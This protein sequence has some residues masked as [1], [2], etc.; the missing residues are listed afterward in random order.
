M[1]HNDKFFVCIFGFAQQIVCPANR[2]L[3][4]IILEIEHEILL[5][6]RR[7]IK[8]RVMRSIHAFISGNA[9][10][11]TFVKIIGK[12]GFA[13]SA[14]AAAD[15]VVVIAVDDGKR[16]FGIF[17]YF[18]GAFGDFPLR[19]GVVVCDIAHVQDHFEIGNES[20]V[21]VFDD[22]IHL[23]VIGRFRSR[24]AGII[25]RIGENDKRPGIAVAAAIILAR[26]VDAALRRAAFFLIFPFVAPRCGFDANLRQAFGG[27][28]F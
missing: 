25:L 13:S 22:P 11:I 24:F 15:F 16:D 23:L 17:Q 4:G 20:S 5:V 19:I 3:T 27:T 21:F 1:R 10:K 12:F 18:M 7:K 28:L 8:I 26:S 9:F 14:D 2:L 6:S